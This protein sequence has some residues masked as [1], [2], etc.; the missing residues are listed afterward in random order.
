VVSSLLPVALWRLNC[1]WH[2]GLGSGGSSS[3]CLVGR[4][5]VLRTCIVA[6]GRLRV[7]FLSLVPLRSSLL[8]VILVPV[9]FAQ[10]VLWGMA[11]LVALVGDRSGSLSLL[12]ERLGKALLSTSG[13]LVST[14]TFW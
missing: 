1:S 4:R 3:T 11:C 9:V 8:G 7:G 14:L 13:L 10:D 2:L 12:P 5:P 6:A